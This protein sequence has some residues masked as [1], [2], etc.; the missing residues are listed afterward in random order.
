M[1]LSVHSSTVYHSQDPEAAQ[2]IINRYMDKEDV[3]MCSGISLIHKQEW[4]FAICNNMG[5]PR[6]YHTE[7]NKS[8]K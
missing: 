3:H 1:H 5:G 8:E 4:N 7:W 6:D 2:V